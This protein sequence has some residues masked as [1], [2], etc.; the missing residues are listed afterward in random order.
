MGSAYKK[1]ELIFNKY[2]RNLEWVQENPK[3]GFEPIVKDGYV[4][5]LCFGVFDRTHLDSKSE[6]P[7][8][9]DHNPPRILGGKSGV[10]TCRNCNSKSGT[11]LDA[12]LLKVLMENDFKDRLPNSKMRTTVE[13]NGNKI[14]A[15]V[16]VDNIGKVRIDLLKQYSNPQDYDQLMEGGTMIYASPQP[17]FSGK[18]TPPGFKEVAVTVKNPLNADVRRAEVTLLKIAYL[19]AFELLGYGMLIHP[20]MPI[21]R[22]QILNPGK[23][24]LPNI[25]S[26]ATEVSKELLGLNFLRSPKQLKCF[27]I[28]FEV[29]TKSNSR[30]FSVPLPGWSE[31]GLD[32]YF[33]DR[34]NQFINDETTINCDLTNF[35]GFEYVTDK[36]AAFTALDVWFNFES[37]QS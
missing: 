32:I 9:F 36:D 17:F 2:S 33:P 26:I 28:V 29:H 3:L 23:I 30:I 27:L 6:M 34:H 8:T 21:V 12:H 11:H 5:P 25:L 24:L 15:D 20:F 14:T 22:E 16:A 1:R 7:L 18:P 37:W 19:H 10:L 35:S 13:N 31:P 4:C